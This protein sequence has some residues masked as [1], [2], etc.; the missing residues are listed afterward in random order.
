MYYQAAGSRGTTEQRGLERQR[1]LD[2]LN[3]WKFDAVLQMFPLL[4]QLGLLLF[5]TALC[6][7]LWAINVPIAMIVLAFTVLGFVAYLFLLGSAMF[8]P[9]SPFQAP[10]APFLK[11]TISLALQILQPLSKVRNW[12]SKLTQNIQQSM[13]QFGKSHAQLLPSFIVH[14]SLE[15]P[16]LQEDFL[17]VEFNEP[18]AEVPAV[19]WVL[20]TSTDPMMIST[21]A[22]MAIDL[23]WPLNL[24]LTLSMN[25]LD[26]TFHH[27]SNSEQ[28]IQEGM[29][30]PATNCGMAYCSLRLFARAS[31]HDSHKIGWWYGHPP[32]LRTVIEI[33]RDLPGVF[34]ASTTSRVTKWALSTIPSLELKQDL[35]GSLRHILDYFL[36]QFT[37]ENMQTLDEEDV[38]NYLCCLNTFF[39]PCNP[40]LMTQ[41][42]KK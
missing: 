15:S 1:K 3:K 17:G 26:E 31:G 13:L 18:S 7:Y 12:C 40:K 16:P 35:E 30:H 21:A 9:D 8:S 20:E 33:Y 4:L 32:E 41:K 6:V 28:N 5:S 10:L 34:N 42:S 19:L 23:Q 27:W 2:G 14:S 25:R 39:S 24:D 37:L 22:E 38:C 29:A 36:K 11:H